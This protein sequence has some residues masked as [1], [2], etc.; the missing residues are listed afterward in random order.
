MDENAR[1]ENYEKLLSSSLARI[2]DLLKFAETKNAAL[3]TFASAWTVGLVNVLR[4]LPPPDR[5]HDSLFYAIVLFIG[6]AIVS[7]SSLLPRANLSRF[8]TPVARSQGLLFLGDISQFDTDEFVKR[9]RA[10]YLGTN[11]QSIRDEYLHDLAV[12]IS[13][14]SQIAHRKFRA[15]NVG[16]VLALI[17]LLVLAFSYALAAA[18]WPK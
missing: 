13:V 12:Q 5:N 8:Y 3:L 18:G 10:R 4:N 15:F 6:A 14:T 16:V 17:A 1:L 11:E 9:A 7:I 2:L